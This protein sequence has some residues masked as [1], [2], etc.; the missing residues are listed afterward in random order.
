MPDRGSYRSLYTCI[1]DDPEF[2][3]LSSDARLVFYTLKFSPLGNV[4]GI[5]VYHTE[6]G[7]T[8]S[9]LP[10]S[11][12][13]AALKRLQEGRWVVRQ[14]PIVWIRNGLRFEPGYSMADPN[15]KRGIEKLLSG[16]PPLAILDEFAESYTC[17]APRGP[18]RSPP[19]ALPG[20]S[21]GPPP[22]KESGSRSTETDPSAATHPARAKAPAS[23]GNG[24]RVRFDRFWEVWTY[25]VAKAQAE[26]TFE[27]LCT[28][29]ELPG[30][31]DLVSAI[32]WQTE[33]G[34]LRPGK[35]KD[36]RDTRPHPSTWLNGKRWTDE[37]ASA[38]QLDPRERQSETF[39]RATVGDSCRCAG[40][41]DPM[42]VT[43]PTVGNVCPGCLKVDAGRAS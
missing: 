42:T 38:P 18:L 17:E 41:D 35:A 2:Q 29:G 40:C 31:E 20:P 23:S 16:L 19:R 8:H 43:D 32:R 12:F 14:G 21:P 24:W 22:Y 9:G 28:A 25:R 27:K 37:P 39:H 15:K 5:F 4:A 11:R 36:G 30:D 3:T 7:V 10:R 34:C 33:S 13:E 1:Q 26:T 6:A